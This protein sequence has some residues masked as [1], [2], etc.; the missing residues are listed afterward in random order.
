V[1]PVLLG[2]E[3]SS[4]V[5]KDSDPCGL[6]CTISASCGAINPDTAALARVSD[7]EAQLKRALNQA[8]SKLTPEQREELPPEQRRWVKWK[9][10]LPDEEGEKVTEERSFRS[11]S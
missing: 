8:W 10:T 3:C 1:K 5:G 6:P 4:A 9:N 7:S 11:S 2:L